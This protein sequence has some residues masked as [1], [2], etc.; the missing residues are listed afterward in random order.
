MESDCNIII[1][2]SNLIKNIYRT[3]YAGCNILYIQIEFWKE[4]IIFVPIIHVIVVVWNTILNELII[5]KILHFRLLD[6]LALQM[7]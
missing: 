7:I 6:K 4:I 2:N 3:K 5:D 1:G